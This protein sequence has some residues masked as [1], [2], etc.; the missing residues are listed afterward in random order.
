MFPFHVG[1]DFSS[2]SG[3]AGAM[4]KVGSGIAPAIKAGSIKGGF[5]PSLSV[6]Y[7]P[8]KAM[9][10]PFFTLKKPGCVMDL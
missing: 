9:A 4:G 6:A 8:S 10:S 2:A 5:S 1:V 7:G 3:P